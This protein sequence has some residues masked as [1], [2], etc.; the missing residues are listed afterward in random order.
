MMAFGRG[1]GEVERELSDGAGG[2]GARALE[3]FSSF[4]VGVMETKE[5]QMRPPGDDVSSFCL[6]DDDDEGVGEM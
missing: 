4:S 1:I 3:S 6:R 5:E 2:P